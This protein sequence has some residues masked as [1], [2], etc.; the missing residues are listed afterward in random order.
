[1]DHRQ[2]RNRTKESDSGLPHNNVVDMFV[3]CERSGNVDLIIIIIIISVFL[4]HL[5]L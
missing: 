5:T 3:E 2:L 4:E 1:M